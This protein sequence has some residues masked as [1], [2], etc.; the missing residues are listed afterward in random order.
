[1]RKLCKGIA[2]AVAFALAA[3]AFAGDVSDTMTEKKSEAAK[4]VR[5]HRP[6][7]E[8]ASDKVSDA[9]DTAHANAAK[10]RKKA[11]KAKRK[12]TAKANQATR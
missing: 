8:S 6:G 12:T 3:P 9:R 1:M 11:R 10:A 2:V 7:G 4:D 5:E